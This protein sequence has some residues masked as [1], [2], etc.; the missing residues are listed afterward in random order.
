M[1]EFAGVANGTVAPHREGPRHDVWD[2]R[3]WPGEAPAP[4]HGRP[5]LGF[6]YKQL[7]RVRARP[8]FHAGFRLTHWNPSDLPLLIR[9]G[10]G[11][12]IE[13][14]VLRRKAGHETLL[15]GGLVWTRIRFGNAGTAQSGQ[16]SAPGDPC[17]SRTQSEIGAVF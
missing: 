13:A 1:Q 12:I 10:S 3:A 11:P 6:S 15:I 17:G 7:E 2:P 4:V 9:G 5:E 16:S 8:I 14:A